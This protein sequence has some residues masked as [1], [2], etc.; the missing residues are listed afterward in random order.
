MSDKKV[1]F[2]V[3]PSFFGVSFAREAHK[4]GFY[5]VVLVSAKDNPQLYGYEGEYDDLLV[6]DIRDADSIYQAIYSS[7]YKR[8]DAMISATDYAMATT[9]EAAQRLN[10]P[11]ISHETAT[12]ARNKDLAR[13]RYSERGVPSAQ[14]KIVHR[15]GEAEDAAA[16]IGYPVVLKPTNTASSQNVFFINDRQQL[17]D[18]FK[19][20]ENFTTSYMGFSVRKEYLVEE[21]LEGPEFSVEIFLT[22][23]EVVFAEVTE[24]VTSP[25]PYFV[26]MFH[27]FPTS[28]LE[29]KKPQMIEVARQALEAIGFTNGPAHVEVKYT[30]TGPRIV[31]V[32]GRPG[33]DNI[34]SDLIPGAYHLNIFRQAVFNALKLPVDFTVEK[35][36]SCAVGYICADRDGVLASIE[37][38]ASVQHDHAVLRSAISVRPGDN[39][40]VPKSSDDRLGYFIVQAETPAKAKAKIT[41]LIGKLKLTYRN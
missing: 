2:L 25:L 26:E 1:I 15:L 37:N 9:A 41:E 31:E 3:E 33:G 39:V 28:V 17:R 19:V 40:V 4:A 36:M 14:F 23:G 24:K 34:T 21:Y 30:Q 6:C 20:L 38:L 16:T 22:H 5:V 13:I 18:A 7:P 8:I 32:N 27:I 11:C 12:L 10:I 35:P 29:D